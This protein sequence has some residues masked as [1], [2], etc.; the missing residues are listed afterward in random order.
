MET[1]SIT[2][3]LAELKLLDKRID[4]QINQSIFLG[5]EINGVQNYKG[6]QPKENLQSVEDLIKRRESIKSA[7]MT[8]N[9]KTEVNIN[10][11]KMTVVQAIEQKETIKYK[12]KLL[13][14]LISDRNSVRANMQNVNENA[15]YRLDNLLQASFS[16]DAKVKGEEIEAIA[17]PF[18]ERNAA[19]ETDIISIDSAISK[20][21]SEIDGFISE[22]DYV[23][24]ESNSLTKIEI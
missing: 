3:A 17:K 19:T 14:K 16:K 13:Q 8:S 20:L 1:I 24:S 15:Q 11:I 5:F 21:E 4:K 18:L 10:G 9:S 22:V 23:L 6:F 12:Q 2:K 7:I